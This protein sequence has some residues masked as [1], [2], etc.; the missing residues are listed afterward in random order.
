MRENLTSLISSSSCSTFYAAALHPGAFTRFVQAAQRPV[1]RPPCLSPARCPG[2]G[3]AGATTEGGK[4]IQAQACSL[5]L[6]K[7]NKKLIDS[8]TPRRLPEEPEMLFKMIIF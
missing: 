5:T 2:D 3:P 1:L 4:P 7:E 6:A 8:V